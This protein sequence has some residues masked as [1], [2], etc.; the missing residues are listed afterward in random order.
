MT[1]YKLGQY[2]DVNLLKLIGDS[3]EK[4]TETKAPIT[5]IFEVPEALRGEGRNYSVIRVHGDETTVLPDTDN[6]PNTV[7]IETDKFST[8]A[9]AYSEKSTVTPP[10]E[11]D[12]GNDD[13]TSS[14][15]N[16]SGNSDSTPSES[17]PNESGNTP[18][19]SSGSSDSDTPSP[20][21][22]NS[23]NDDSESNSN[24]GTS[25]SDEKNSSPSESASADNSGNPSTGIAVS[26]VPLAGAITVLMVTVKRKRK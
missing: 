3:Q 23:S 12:P 18:S 15:E 25:S 21:D 1:D 19:D 7:T 20:S 14:D 9:L 16:D 4:I 6:D 11:S 26:L 2:I 10:D 17:E 24:D 13:S 22:G 8:Y 5:V